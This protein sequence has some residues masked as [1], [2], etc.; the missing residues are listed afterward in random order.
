MEMVVVKS[1]YN[2]YYEKILNPGDVPQSDKK[3]I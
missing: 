1:T 3:A 2:L